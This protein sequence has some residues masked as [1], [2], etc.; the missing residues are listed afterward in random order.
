M[1][2]YANYERLVRRFFDVFGENAVLS[3]RLHGTLGGEFATD[4]VESVNFI[5]RLYDVIDARFSRR[6]AWVDRQGTVL[7]L[8]DNHGLISRDLTDWC[9]Q[10]TDHYVGWGE[11]DFGDGKVIA[12][13][14][15]L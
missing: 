7:R 13:L 14:K 5:A 1:E 12:G 9:R 2:F 15:A 10:S 8:V 6:K 3:D 4:E 11:Q